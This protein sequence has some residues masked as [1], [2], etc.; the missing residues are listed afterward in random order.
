MLRAVEINGLKKHEFLY[1]CEEYS[2]KVLIFA[3]VFEV[4]VQWFENCVPF[5]LRGGYVRRKGLLP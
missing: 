3:R 1:P 2:M 5:G 4:S